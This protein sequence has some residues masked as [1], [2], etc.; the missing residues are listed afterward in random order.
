MAQRSRAARGQR[1]HAD[2]PEPEQA[3]HGGGEG[4]PTTYGH[5]PSGIYLCAPRIWN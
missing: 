3:R 5:G 2:R 1:H 4:W